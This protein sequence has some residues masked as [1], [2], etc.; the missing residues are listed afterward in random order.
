MPCEEE[1]TLYRS[2][3][4]IKEGHDP[5]SFASPVQSQNLSYKEKLVRHLPG[6]YESTF[7]LADLMQHDTDSDVKEDDLEEGTIVVALSKEQKLRIQSQWSNALI[8]KTFG[9]T[10][11]YQFLS[12][13]VC[14]L[15]KP[16][17]RL[18]IVD[19]G[20]DF[21][22]A[23][24]ESNED[25]NHV[26]KNGLWFIRQHFLAI[27]AWEPEFKATEANFSQVAI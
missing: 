17:N 7:R 27:K 16:N 11:V 19:L 18:D 3:K 20:Q 8:I 24:F 6:A 10:A 12:Q 21:F 26:L 2:T 15:W 9:R 1:D 13:C 5:S 23:R 22:L 25:L 14:D 4:K